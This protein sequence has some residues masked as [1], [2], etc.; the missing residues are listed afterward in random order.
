MTVTCTAS[1]APDQAQVPAGTD[2]TINCG[3]ATNG[4]STTN[5][6][7]DLFANPVAVP[8]DYGLNPARSAVDGVP[9]SAIALPGGD[10]AV[11]H[12]PRGQPAHGRRQR[13]LRG[14]SATRAR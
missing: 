4:N 2:G 1:D 7:T 5:P 8:P 13:Q 11:G 14:A 9:A 12:R 6:L 10:H 3:N